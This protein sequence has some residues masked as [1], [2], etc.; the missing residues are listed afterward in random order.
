MSD[1]TAAAAVAAAA[2][3]ALLLRQRA[4]ARDPHHELVRAVREAEL[5]HEAALAAALTA[6]HAHD[7]AL[8]AEGFDST[9]SDEGDERNAGPASLDR[10]SVMLFAQLK[11]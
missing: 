10:A 8:A 7:T 9:E 5:A 2:A 11:F 3:T 1:R 4:L 6:S